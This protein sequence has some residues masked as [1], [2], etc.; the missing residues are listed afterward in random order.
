[1]KTIAYFKNGNTITAVNRKTGNLIIMNGNGVRC[2]SNLVVQTWES[3]G[4]S[5]HINGNVRDIV[6]HQI[7]RHEDNP[8]SIWGKRIKPREIKDQ[9]K[10]KIYHAI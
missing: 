10:T 4:R 1:M 8:L 2:T 6:E 7:R 3:S 9:L 5:L